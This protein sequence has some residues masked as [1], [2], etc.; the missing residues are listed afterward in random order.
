MSGEFDHKISKVKGS[1]ILKS[2]LKKKMSRRAAAAV[3]VGCV[4]LCALVIACAVSIGS[5][6]VPLGTVARIFAGKLG[7]G[8][9]AAIRSSDVS[10]V[11]D[12]RFPRAV[13]A[14]LVGAGLSVAGCVMQAVLKN[15]LASSYTLGVSAGAALGAGVIILFPVMSLLLGTFTLPLAGFA[16]GLATV[17]FIM[18]FS[19]RIDASVKSN[20]LILMGVVLSQFLSSLLTLL[21]VLRR[22]KMQQVSMWLLGSFAS[23][24]WIE[25][26][27]V[28]TGVVL[29]LLVILPRGRELDILSLGE[30]HAKTTGVDPV[31]MKWLLLM[32]SS[33]I[34]GCCVAFTGIIGFI[35][36]IAPHVV[37]RVF[38]SRHTKVIPLCAIVGGCFMVVCDLI[39]R[40]IASPSELPV[41]V[42]SAIIGAPFFA[43][44]FF[45]RKKNAV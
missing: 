29:G 14:F 12:I 37:R 3:A 10:I 45:S 7:G 4:M 23:S 27:V 36:L 40:T 11:W 30:D 32:A 2:T 25:I 6:S 33:A 31:R 15:P 26:A 38:G 20:T 22:E 16:T 44:I 24:R 5:V 34:I 18:Q 17:V 42:V 41:G 19:R 43:Y 9:D 21:S 8:V 28:L 1:F 13:M 39:A 35:D